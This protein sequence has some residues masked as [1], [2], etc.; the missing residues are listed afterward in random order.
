MKRSAV[1][2]FLCLSAVPP[3]GCTRTGIL[4]GCPCPDRGSRVSEVGFEL[5]TFRSVNS[6]SN[7]LGYLVP[8]TFDS[9][10]HDTYYP[11]LMSSMQLSSRQLSDYCASLQIVRFA[12]RTQPQHPRHQKGAIA[13]RLFSMIVWPED[14]NS[15]Q[16]RIHHLSYHHITPR[17]RVS[18]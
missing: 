6:C 14:S 4:P 8:L 12:V 2:P 9:L 16:R 1:T 5:R 13:E 3:E 17:G 18:M 11:R 15:H 10:M 7:H